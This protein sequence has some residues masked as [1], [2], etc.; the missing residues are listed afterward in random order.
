M[1]GTSKS[2][3]ATSPPVEDILVL[4]PTRPVYSPAELVDYIAQPGDTLPALAAHFNTTETEIRDAN[5]VLPDEVTTLP[6]GLP[7]EIPIYHQ[8]LWGISYQILPDYLFANGPAQIDFDTIAY[9]D[10]QPGWLKDYQDFTGG[11]KARGGELVEYVANNFSISPRL[12]LAIIEYQTG[13]LIL[14]TQSN[15]DETYPLG[16]HDILHKRLYQQLVWAANT[17]N[18][19]FYGWRTGRLT[20]F[21]HLDGRL[22]RPDPWQNAATVA[23]QY[24]F[25]Q[26]LPEKSYIKA[27]HSDGL[28]QVYNDL[29]GDPWSNIE[30]YIPGSLQQPPMTLPF[31]PGKSWAYTGGPHTGWGKGDPLAAIDFA[32][33]NVEG[34]CVPT[35]EWATAVADGVIIRSGAARAYLDLDGDADERTGWVVLYLHLATESIAPNGTQVK[36]GEPVGLPSCEGGEATGTHIHIARKFNGEWI[37]A[38]GP[39]SF[40]LDGWLVRNGTQPYLG[41]LERFGHIVRASVFSD[42]AS[43]IQTENP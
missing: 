28:G 42:Q 36:T 23:I 20:S 8:P 33:P 12:L 17:L 27:I 40:N 2:I 14:S 18:N 26:V 24:Y 30:P 1:V 15:P 9:V 35:K 5:S 19:G 11:E 21:E 32:P 6:A 25:A 34:G 29:F 37:P 39:L 16:Y 4:P 22:E 43:Q 41:T 13:A 10:S 7:L 38:D 3:T 31:L